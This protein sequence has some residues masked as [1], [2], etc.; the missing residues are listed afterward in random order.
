M[1]DI[2]PRN[3]Q[4]IVKKLTSLEKLLQK[5]HKC[6]VLKSSQHFCVQEYKLDLFRE[7]LEE[8]GCHLT[9]SR[10][11][12]DLIPFFEKHE[13]DI[14]VNELKG[15]DLSVIFDGTTRLG[16]ALDIVLRFVDDGWKIN[17]RLVRLQMVAKSVNGEGKGA[18]VSDIC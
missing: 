18:Y 5:A 3:S 2:L 11:M 4:F 8:N 6:F 12:Y 15:K 1:K 17:Q 13:F 16:E 14:I 10:N 7:L 9:D